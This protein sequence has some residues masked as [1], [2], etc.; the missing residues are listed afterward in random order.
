MALNLF[1]M[2]IGGFLA[3]SVA[4][5]MMVSQF[6]DSFADGGKKPVGFAA[7]AS[8]IASGTAYLATY[9]NDGLFTIY[10]V[11]TCIFIFFGAV[12][13]FML[14]K[15]FFSSHKKNRQKVFIGE[16]IFGLAVVLFTIVIFSSLQYFLKDKSFL[17]YPV[18]TSTFGFFIPMLVFHTFLAANEI[19]PAEFVTWQYPLH[20]KLE[21]PYD[22]KEQL[23]VIAFEIAKSRT[24]RKKT[25]FRAKTPTTIQLGEFYYHFINDYNERQSETPIEYADNEYEAQEW[26]FRRK[27]K[28]YQNQRIL[29]PNISMRENRIKE[30]TVIVCERLEKKNN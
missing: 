23:L 6:S 11:I 10:W 20:E 9:I 26:W 30:N 21:L 15:K 1:L 29:N 28:W 5:T 8:A 7:I 19:P 24:E 22:D 18:L 27:P 2:Y 16:L 13:I 12:H 3:G 14:H 4:L 25:V 17:F